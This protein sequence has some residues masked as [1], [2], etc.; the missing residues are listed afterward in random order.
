MELSHGLQAIVKVYVI[1]NVFTLCSPE[2]TFTTVDM[3]HVTC[4]L[5]A[6]DAQN[7]V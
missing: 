2:P 5:T 1:I 7:I 6:A 3:R 4:G